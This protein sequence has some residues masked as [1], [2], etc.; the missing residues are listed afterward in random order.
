MLPLFSA[1]SVQTMILAKDTAYNST[2]KTHFFALHT[3]FF[4]NSFL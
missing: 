2:L 1:F 3:Q 4:A